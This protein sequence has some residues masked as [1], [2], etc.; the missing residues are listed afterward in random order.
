MERLAPATANQLSDQLAEGTA[1]SAVIHSATRLDPGLSQ[2]YHY[3]NYYFMGSNANKRVTALATVESPAS[4]ASIDAATRM[5]VVALNVGNLNRSVAYYTEALGFSV[6]DRNGSDVVLGAGGTPL[7]LLREQPGA[8]PWLVDAMTGL[9]HL[10]ILLPTRTDLGRWLR[11]FITLEQP[12]PGQGD[13]IVSEALYI[14]DP[15]GHGIEVYWDRPREGW[16][17]S[18][19][20]VKMGGGPVDV[21]SMLAQADAEGKPW[22]GL[23]AGTIIGH[24]HLQVGDI[25][26]AEEFYHGVLGFD[27]VSQGPTALFVSAG[28]YHHH[29]GMNTWHSK[30]AAPA[31]VD[32]ATLRFFSVALPSREAQAE[33][34]TRIAAAGIPYEEVGETVVLRDP[35]QNTIVLQPRV[36][37]DATTAASLATP[38]A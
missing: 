7:L 10:A 24:V 3:R 29:L 37:T 18:N 34:V 1:Q 8:L 35:W 2:S 14:R 22:S 6:L 33:V 30:G 11:H 13:H 16:E 21:R 17:W 32:T 38:T 28:G 23:P 26:R 31:P 27:V 25:A 4:V 19:G 20:R 9:Y 15:D 5:G 12:P 36:V